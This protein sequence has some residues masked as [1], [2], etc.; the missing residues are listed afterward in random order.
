MKLLSYI[1][2]AEGGTRSLN[3]TRAKAHFDTTYGLYRQRATAVAEVERVQREDIARRAAE[4]A[5]EEEE[6]DPEAWKLD[7][8]DGYAAFVADDRVGTLVLPANTEVERWLREPVLLNPTH[9]EM[10]AY[11]LAKAHEF[12]IIM[13]MARDFMAIPATSAPSERTF[14]YAGNLITKKRTRISSNNVRYVLCLR[15]WGAIVDD[16]EEEEVLFDR[17]GE[18]IRPLLPPVRQAVVV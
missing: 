12:P 14:S 1:Y 2:A 18:Y 3:Y 7:P 15:S 8:L 9:E 17:Y 13:Q 10:K 16:D 4:G 6:V 5:G 11:M